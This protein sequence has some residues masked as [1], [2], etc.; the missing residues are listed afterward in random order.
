MSPVC[1]DLAE[2]M[3]YIATSFNYNYSNLTILA[4]ACRQFIYSDLGVNVTRFEYRISDYWIT[5]YNQ[6]LAQC[7]ECQSFS[8]QREATTQWDVGCGQK[9][10]LI[11]QF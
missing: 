7:G 8:I 3:R 10:Q 9:P 5:L 1:Q 6:H 11:M 4:S 2:K